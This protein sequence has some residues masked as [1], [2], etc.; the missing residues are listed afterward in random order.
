MTVLTANWCSENFTAASTFVTSCASIRDYTEWM[1]T[2]R[3]PQ[4]CRCLVSL[5]AMATRSTAR[6]LQPQPSSLPSFPSGIKYHP[7]LHPFTYILT[8]HKFASQSSDETIPLSHR[9]KCGTLDWTLYVI[10]VTFSLVVTGFYWLLP[11]LATLQLWDCFIET[12]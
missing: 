10:L 11:S 5:G 1:I 4:T 2:S 9:N 6:S 7:C 8:V 3:M 12:P